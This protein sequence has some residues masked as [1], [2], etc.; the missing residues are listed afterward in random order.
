MDNSGSLLR[1]IVLIIVLASGCFSLPA[2]ADKRVALVI[3][4]AAYAHVARLGNPQN[5]AQLIAETLHGL[6]FTLVGGGPLLNLDKAA[7]DRA[8]QDFG[9]SLEGADV[10][11]FYYAGH[12]L[13]VDGINYLVPVDADPTKKADLDFQMLD[14]TTVIRQMSGAKLSLVLTMHAE[15][16]RLPSAACAKSVPGWR[17][18]G[19]RKTR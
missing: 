13:Q 19:R 18:C 9:R 7:I 6:G 11:L 5:D 16:I 2:Y 4:N 10:G 8:V 12:G 17:R 15:T 1:R 14:A 3:G